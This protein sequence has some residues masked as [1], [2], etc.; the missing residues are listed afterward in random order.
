MELTYPKRQPKNAIASFSSSTHVSTSSEVLSL[1]V[2][3]SPEPL[4][5]IEYP[6]LSLL[7]EW[8]I[9]CDA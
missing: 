4:A 8:G 3:K 1:V 9:Q 5:S 2:Q 6:T 7:T